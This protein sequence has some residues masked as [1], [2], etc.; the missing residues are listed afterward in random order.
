MSLIIQLNLS[1]KKKPGQSRDILKNLAS[2]GT[3]KEI[4]LLQGHL[5]KLGFSKDALNN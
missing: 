4:G 2:Q 1:L 5:K 3:P